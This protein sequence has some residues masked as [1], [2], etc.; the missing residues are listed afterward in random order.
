MRDDGV[1][2]PGRESRD[3]NVEFCCQPVQISTFL[4]GALEQGLQ[5]LSG[6]A[7]TGIL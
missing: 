3:P 1:S 4:R 2:I 6:S 5:R 7:I